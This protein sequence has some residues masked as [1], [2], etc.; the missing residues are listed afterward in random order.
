MR[1]LVVPIFVLSSLAGCDLYFE[2]P[3]AGADAAPG[4]VA[5]AWPGSAADAGTVPPPDAAPEPCEA[6]VTGTCQCNGEPGVLVP[7][8]G[9]DA[10]LCGTELER[11]HDGM[12]GTWEGVSASPWFEHPPGT[13]VRFVFRGDGT[14]SAT[15]Q[16]ACTALYYGTDQDDPAKRWELQDVW[17][18]GQG[19]GRLHVVFDPATVLQGEISAIELGPDATELR[20]EFW[21]TWGGRYGPLVYD[22]YRCAP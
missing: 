4:S 16:G 22:L 7:R 11:L 6:A 17:A 20:F 1:T 2:P 18:N 9:G 19:F 10:C 15:C 8:A 14:Y 12:V 5:D 21:R 3:P 13:P